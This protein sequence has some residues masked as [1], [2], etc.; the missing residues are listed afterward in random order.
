MTTTRTTAKKASAAPRKTVTPRKT[1]QAPIDT[2]KPVEDPT[3]V[4]LIH[5]VGYGLSYFGYNWEPGQELEIVK[6]SADYDRTCD[7]TGKSWLDM[8]EEEQISRWGEVKFRKG[9]SDIPNA[10]IHYKTMPSEGFDYFG[11]PKFGGYMSSVER[12]KAAQAEIERGRKV[13]VV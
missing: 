7:A 9:P 6:S 3:E 4:I 8:T 1:V 11:R 2:P 13:P 10:V 5:F 12:E